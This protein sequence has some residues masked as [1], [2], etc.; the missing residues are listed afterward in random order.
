M[1]SPAHLIGGDMHD[2][3]FEP[4]RTRGEKH[5]EGVYIPPSPR[6]TTHSHI[7]NQMLYYARGV[8]FLELLR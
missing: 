3:Q 4:P 2:Y 7:L 1:V 8:H 6:M 5:P